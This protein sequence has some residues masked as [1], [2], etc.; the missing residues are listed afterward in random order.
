MLVSAPEPEGLTEQLL[1]PEGA[2]WAP[3]RG[4][5]IF[6]C[7]DLRKASS[8]QASLPEFLES[9]YQAGVKTAGWDI[10]GSRAVPVG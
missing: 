8:P 9:A 7:D 10:E 1:R 2:F 4:T 6:M 5:D 3:V